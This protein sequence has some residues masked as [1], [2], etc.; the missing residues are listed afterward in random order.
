[1]RGGEFEGG[2]ALKEMCT[3]PLFPRPAP[4]VWW[5]LSSSSGDPVSGSSGDPRG[6]SL[7]VLPGG[8]IRAFLYCCVAVSGLRGFCTGGTRTLPF[9][10]Q[11]IVS[12]V[13][14]QR[15]ANLLRALLSWVRQTTSSVVSPITAAQRTPCERSP[16]A[17]ESTLKELP[18]HS[19]Q[20]AVVVTFGSFS[21]LLGRDPDGALR[22]V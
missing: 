4:Y 7:G 17:R 3:T 11:R 15:L 20:V 9:P 16:R 8:Q 14:P 6:I 21:G 5:I 10:T 18:L 12:Q 1:M 19:S 22:C 2:V 13:T